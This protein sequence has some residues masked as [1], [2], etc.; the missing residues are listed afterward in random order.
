M[1]SS[2]RVLI[3]DDHEIVREGLETLLSEEAT[4]T[5]VGQAANGIEAVALA[6]DLR[7]DV[8]LMDL[9]M[10][11][12]DG[13]EATRRIRGAGLACQVLVLTSFADDQ[14]VR[15]ALEAGAIGYL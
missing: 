8:I 3:V 1:P 7:P 6:T 12:L 2:V 14:K 13:L 11:E 5:L 10:P 9:V 4:I 15:E